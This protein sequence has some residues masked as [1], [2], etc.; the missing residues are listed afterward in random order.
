MYVNMYINMYVDVSHVFS[1]TE[2][3]CKSNILYTYI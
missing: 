3:K 1:Y 2:S